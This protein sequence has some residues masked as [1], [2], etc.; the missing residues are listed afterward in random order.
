MRFPGLGLSGTSSPFLTFLAGVRE[1]L[2][3]L[4]PGGWRVTVEVAVH[5]LLGSR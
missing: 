2:H 5:E 1:G 3:H 4:D